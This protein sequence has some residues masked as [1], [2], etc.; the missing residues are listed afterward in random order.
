MRVDVNGAHLTI[1]TNAHVAGKIDMG[2]SGSTLTL[3]NTSGKWVY[4]A[5]LP[6]EDISAGGDQYYTYPALQNAIITNFGS[7][8]AICAQNI[9]GGY[10]NNMGIPDSYT[11]S[12]TLIIRKDN[13]IP[14]V[15]TPANPHA[16]NGVGYIG[17]PVAVTAGCG[18]Q[19]IYTN[20]NDPCQI[21]GCFLAGTHILT[22]A[23]E[24][25]VETLVDGDEI[26]VIEN[27]ETVYR[28][29][30]WLGRSHADVAALDFDPDA[31]PVR[32]RK[33]AFGDNMPHRDL[34]VTSEHSI[35][36]DGRLVPV[37][38]LVN[39]RSITV[40]RSITDYD[41][42]HVELEQ[43][44]VIVS[45]GL[46]TESY[47]DTGNRGTFENS[48]VRT[49]RPHFAGGIT[50]SGGK[51]W[52][53][54]AA[55][56][57]T[58][59][60]ETVEPIWHRLAARAEELGL[61]SD[62]APVT[63][64]EETNIRLVTENGREIRPVR[65]AGNTYSFMVPGDVTSVRI[66]TNASR[67]ADVVGPFCDDRRQLGVVVGDVNVTAGRS[68]HSVSAHLTATA[69]EGWQAWEGGV[70]RWTDGNAVLDLGAAGD[71]LFARMVEIE[72][73]TGGPYI[74]ETAESGAQ[75]A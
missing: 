28:P 41:F 46:A 42:Y 48:V 45:E 27:G 43:H 66:A 60:R 38:M 3:E 64:T 44:G 23:G 26:A 39:G 10:S 2:T 30:A 59:D 8:S 19:S 11:S 33:D 7:N 18:D 21:E 56:P 53:S 5:N 67:P 70:G 65:H 15:A 14:T 72:V 20:P 29:L 50:I 51:S 25:L 4:E 75:V 74:V 6:G 57:L 22:R 34:L 36:I 31:Y 12:S 68:R 71:N 16:N 55:A 37:R 40:E 61:A 49:L 13:S 17:V 47:L 54:N 24:K 1:D 69:L 73:L 9:P 32:I 58:T 62:A 52:E 35:F 63:T